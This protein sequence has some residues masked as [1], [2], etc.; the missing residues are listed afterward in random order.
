MKT[1]VKL[2]TDFSLFEGGKKLPLME[3]ASY[4]VEPDLWK[5]LVPVL[6]LSSTL[7]SLEYRRIPFMEV[8]FFVLQAI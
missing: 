7:P 6:R 3:E 1:E 8:S 2:L 4:A 5:V